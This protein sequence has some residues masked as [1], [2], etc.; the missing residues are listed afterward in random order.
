MSESNISSLQSA[1]NKEV[2]EDD[3]VPLV[4]SDS[5][6][7]RKLPSSGKLDLLYKSQQAFVQYVLISRIYS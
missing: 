2:S 6:I 5:L 1:A 4:S 7:F 3:D